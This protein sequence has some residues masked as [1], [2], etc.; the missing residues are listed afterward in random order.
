M[1]NM[2]ECEIWQ[3]YK[4]QTGYGMK[5]VNYK[6]LKAHRWIWSQANGEIPNG[7]VL[8]HKCHG[9]ALTKGE[10]KGGFS[11]IHR[12]C[13]NLDHLELV[14]PSENIKRGI[15]AI[16]N[17]ATCRKGHDYKNP[18]NIMLRAN[19]KRECSQC[20]RER[21]LVNYYKGKGS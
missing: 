17:R 15:Q 12:A 13:V 5:V 18:K 21:A 7:Y 11:C 16:D 9:E 19:G 14:T 1:D 3:G 6:R 4:S 10:C 2:S 8:D 20:N